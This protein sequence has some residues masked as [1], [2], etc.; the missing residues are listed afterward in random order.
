AWAN[1]TPCAGREVRKYQI[2]PD[3]VV[4][5]QAVDIVE[6]I[7]SLIWRR[8]IVQTSCRNRKWRCG[9]LSPSDAYGSTIK[10]GGIWELQGTIEVLQGQGVRFGPIDI[11]GQPLLI[12]GQLG[13]GTGQSVGGHGQQS[14]VV[15]SLT[16]GLLH[17]GAQQRSDA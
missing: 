8:N 15:R 13:R 10:S 1:R 2:P 9:P 5:Y 12:A 14:Q 6:V 11:V 16:A 3:L 4:K 7:S 17:L